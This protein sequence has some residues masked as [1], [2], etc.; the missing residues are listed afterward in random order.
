MAKKVKFLLK[1]ADEAQVRSLEELREHFDLASVLGYYDDGRL[2]EWLTDRY[3]EA[4]AKKVEALDP[5]ASDFKK[6]LC[7]ILGVDYSKIGADYVSLTGISARNERLKRLKEFTADD[8]V[9][10]AVDSVAFTQEE[11]ADLLDEGVNEIYLCG[12]QFRIPG[13]KGGVTYIGVNNPRVVFPEKYAAK[14]NIFKN[15]DIGIDDIMQHAKE[16]NDPVDAVRLWRLAAEMG[17]ASAQLNLGT[18]YRDGEGVEKDYTEAVKWFR[19]AAEQG[20]ALAQNRLGRR[21]DNGEGVEK[22]YA[23]AVK[24][25]RKAA[26]QGDAIAQCNLGNCYLSGRGVEKDYTEAVEWYRK[27][28]EQGN[29]DAQFNLGV[30]YYNGEGVAQ[31]YAEANK[32]YRKAAEQGHARAQYN[33]GVCYSNGEGVA[34]DYTEA[35]KWYRKAA[36]QGDNVAQYNLGI[37]Y[38]DGEGVE[39]NEEEAIKWLRKAADKGDEQARDALKIFMQVIE[40]RRTQWQRN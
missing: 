19:K 4:E 21:Y 37:S 13:S 3:Y 27:A 20:N 38:R 14:G 24:W 1:M 10:A 34:Q 8:K 23:E 15:V 35:N 2:I 18:S 30:C 40:Q 28:A 29:A 6:S 39:Q 5:K 17:D 12:K 32:W 22:D 11:L 33:L 26:D 7:E 31:D 9:L 36:E 25:Y 16:S